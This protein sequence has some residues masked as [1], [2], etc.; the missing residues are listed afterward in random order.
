MGYELDT[1]ALAGA[2][3]GGITHNSQGDDTLYSSSYPCSAPGSLTT[4]GSCKLNCSA[5]LPSTH[6]DE[7]AGWW[8]MQMMIP[9][10]LFKPEFA[11]TFAKA[12]PWPHWRANLYRY[13]YPFKF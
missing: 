2:F 10:G 13:S 4:F 7:G 11:P 1:G 9:W 8:G 6:V 5:T 12:A 3:W